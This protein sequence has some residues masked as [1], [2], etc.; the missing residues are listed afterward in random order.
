VINSEFLDVD[1][2]NTGITKVIA[3]LDQD[4]KGIWVP[5][6]ISRVP[7]INNFGA[8]TKVNKIDSVKNAV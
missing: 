1:L 2:P 4:Q 5:N 3:D 6:A 7:K 8:V